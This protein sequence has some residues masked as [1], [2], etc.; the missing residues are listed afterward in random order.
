MR[1]TLLFFILLSGIIRSQALTVDRE[2]AHEAFYGSI[3][4]IKSAPEKLNIHQVIA[5][6]NKGQ[7]FAPVSYG[8]NFPF[9][10]SSYWIYFD[11]SNTDSVT[12]EQVLAI[13]NPN[14][15]HLDIYKCFGDS[16]IDSVLTGELRPY[17]NREIGHT[18]FLFELRIPAQSSMRIF[19]Y[20]DND[21]DEI[22]IPITLSSQHIFI[23]KHLTSTYY[24]YTLT[25]MLIFVI[26]SMLFLVAMTRTR[27]SVF[28]LLYVL[29]VSFFLLSKWGLS[30]KFMSFSGP[31]MAIYFAPICVSFATI[32]AQYFNQIFLNSQRSSAVADKIIHSIKWASWLSMGTFLLPIRYNY[33]P[34]GLIITI[35]AIAAVITP[36][37]GFLCLKKEPRASFF[38][39]LSSLPI[40]TT[41]GLYIARLYGLIQ[42]D[43]LLYGFG[44]AF[45]L[46]IIILTFAI[47]D[48][49]R[50][51]LV[52]SVRSLTE[53]SKNL[54]IQKKQAEES[55]EILKD[56][57]AEKEIM[58]NKLM[59]S[60][61]LETIGKLAG[62]IAHDFNNLLTP[63]IGYSEM[64]IENAEP[65]SELESDLKIILSSSKRAKELVNQILAFSKHFKEQTQHFSIVPIIDEVT[66][67]LKSIIPSSIIIKHRYEDDDQ[68]YLNADPTQIHQILMNICTNSFHAIENKQGMITIEHIVTDLSSNQ[69]DEDKLFINP[70]KYIHIRISDTGKGIDENTLEKIFDP[71]FTTKDIGKGTGLGLS[72]VHGIVK[73]MRGCIKVQSQL[74]IGTSFNVYL[75]LANV[76]K[77]KVDI[78]PCVK[79]SGGGKLIVAVDDEENI[80]NLIEKILI[81]NG[82]TVRS[83]IR[84]TDAVDYLTKTED[85]VSMVITD[86]TM[87]I[88]TGSDLAIQIREANKQMPILLISGYSEIVTTSNY[89]QF[90]INGL[91]LKP[92][93]PS[94]LLEKIGSMLNYNKAIEVDQ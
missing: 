91:M 40:S 22:F 86:Q 48:Q 9:P 16:I 63:I 10:S 82:Y 76:K 83:F 67:L 49:Y 28:F 75:P 61:K 62:G 25:G 12:V 37:Y 89:E 32:T 3:R 90:G 14:I 20:I 87:P 88:L 57:I 80:L 84:S 24:S 81:K 79:I 51:T 46:E 65:D 33:I 71:F 7:D 19:A 2:T 39:M 41:I 21:S 17:S 55:N 47:I 92:I 13:N 56:T 4:Y 70:G 60:H 18:N 43:S 66:T 74:D 5:I 42:S 30:Q 73:R 85:T 6:A 27:I 15:N 54:Q 35:A 77:K 93:A 8:V 50:N 69:I 26:I 23:E 34:Q 31:F 58:Q 1:Q 38:I 53:V 44:T 59:Q 29:S 72:V 36:F 78:Q 52:Y 45:V 94:E 11:I 68:P 64:C